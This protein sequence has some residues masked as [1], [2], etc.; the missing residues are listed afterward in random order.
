MALCCSL[1][2]PLSAVEKSQT[3]DQLAQTKRIKEDLRKEAQEI[4][5]ETKDL[6][7]DFVGKKFWK[8]DGLMD[9][10]TKLEKF[11]SKLTTL[12]DKIRKAIQ[13]IQSSE[14]LLEKEKR[15]QVN[16]LDTLLSDVTQIYNTVGE[17]RKDT[18]EVLKKELSKKPGFKRIKKLVEEENEEET[19]VKLLDNVIEQNNKHQPL[20]DEAAYDDDSDEE[21]KKVVYNHVVKVSNRI[22]CSIFKYFI[23][24]IPNEL[25][26]LDTKLDREIYRDTDEI[27]IIES[28]NVKRQRRN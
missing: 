1:G 4:V 2:A 9:I 15:S 21:L 25:T 19:F 14:S 12:K 6:T 17:A 13:N 5:K 18:L 8:F 23:K 20:V 26:K 28:D 22:V 10:I 16:S 27:D 3:Q 24:H 11:E 7:E